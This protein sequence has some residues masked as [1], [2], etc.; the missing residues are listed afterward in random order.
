M[1]KIYIRKDKDSTYV[2]YFENGELVESYKEDDNK[3]RLEGNI[4]LGIIKDILPGIQ[5]A[6]IDIGEDRNALIHIKDLIPKISQTTGNILM[7][8]EN[9]KIKDI[10]KEDDQLIVQVKRDSSELKGSRVTT[11]IKLIGKYLILMP[12]SKFITVSSKITN[13]KKSKELIK[14]ISENLNGKYGAII[15]TS[16]ENISMDALRNEIKEID[17]KWNEILTKVD[18]LIKKENSKPILLFNNYGIVGKIVTDF[19]YRN[20]PIITNDENIKNIILKINNSSNVKIENVEKIEKPNRK[21]WL[22][23]GGFITI[24]ET[25]ALVAIDVNSGK[26]FGDIRG[27]EKNFLKVNIE[28]TKEIAKQIRLQDIGGIIII[29]YINMQESENREIIKKLM[30]EETKKD[31]SK[32]QIVDFTNL[33]LLEMTRKHILGR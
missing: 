26:Y 2:Y 16:A 22:N 6:F 14:F 3:I 33:G 18:K 32:V 9:Y 20:I 8:E 1:D 29:D 17:E 30:I 5:S 24:D 31:R 7:N 10:L 23:C 28:A 27:I 21:I 11:D 19:E 12:Y 4:Y 13:E 25:E 15:R